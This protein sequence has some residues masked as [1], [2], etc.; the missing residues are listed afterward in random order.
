M[1]TLT[2]QGGPLG[3]TV[4]T[5]SGEAVVGRSAVADL[6]I[7][8]A[9]ISRRHARL[10]HR[11]R[12]CRIEDLGSANGT[13]INGKPVLRPTTLGDGDTVELGVVRLIYTQSDPDAPQGDVRYRDDASHPEVLFAMPAEAPAAGG[14]AAA[15]SGEQVAVELRFLE[16]F[17]KISRM[18][19][20]PDALL[21]FVV[22]ELLE[23]MPRAERAFVML[24]DPGTGELV[25]STIRTRKGA[26]SEIVAS[27]TLLQHVVSSRSAVLVVDTARDARYAEARSLHDLGIRAAVAA[28]MIFQQDLYGI[29][30]VDSTGAVPFADR[31]VA[32]VLSLASQVGL[33]LATARLH[34]AAVRRGL[35]EH[36]MELA[37]K[38]QRH[39]LPREPPALSGYACSFVYRPALGV[40]GDFYDFLDL[41]NNLVGI[42]IGDVSGKGVS[43]ALYAAK[44][45][46]DLRHQA[47]GQTRP[48]TILGRTNRALLGLQDEGMFA[49]AVVAVLDRA[50]GQ[51]EVSIAGHPPPLLRDAAGRVS[52]LGRVGSPPLGLHEKAVFEQHRY[53]L[54]VQS[55]VVFYTDGVTEAISPAEE[56]FGETRLI[57]AIR[58]ATGTADAFKDRLEAAVH[59]F[60]GGQA[61]SDDLTIVCVQRTD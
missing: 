6:V 44:L 52:R 35:V 9:S 14:A 30:Q 11:D 59:A 23:L 50:T 45:T 25:P 28:P 47:A 42:V 46:S 21:S 17:A 60:S 27:R 7:A 49:T 41:G 26:V 32:M 4:L 33:A 20:D 53:I 31:D 61:T 58:H 2:I 15:Q 10:V 16:N 37:T 54:D 36:D 43:A 1:P 22:Q 19:L 48:A 18:V 57:D 29:L 8:D 12:R 3:G 40:G 39:F 34:Q 55:T 5:F 56:L 51:I 38:V 24:R 13:R